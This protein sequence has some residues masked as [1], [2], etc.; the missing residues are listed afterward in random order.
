M[1]RTGKL[2]A[3][4]LAAALTAACAGAGYKSDCY[5]VWI[6]N[7]GFSA[8]TGNWSFAGMCIERLDRNCP[9][10]K[11]FKFAAGVDHNANGVLDSGE[12]MINV[13]DPDPQSNKVCAAAATGSIGPGKK[14]RKILWHYEC[15]KGDETEP[16]VS[17]SG[18]I[19]A[20]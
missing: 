3:L 12:T 1:N 19:E 14:G 2:A 20:D 11:D 4:A 16:F 10:L 5:E 8:K 13:D 15:K 9:D 7:F 6:G 17:N 18:K